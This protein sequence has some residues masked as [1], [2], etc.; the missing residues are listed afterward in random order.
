MFRAGCQSRKALTKNGSSGQLYNRF[1]NGCC[2]PDH[3]REGLIY[4]MKRSFIIIPVLLAVFVLFSAVFSQ[5]EPLADGE[6]TADFKTDSSMFKVCEANDGKGILTV[7]DGEMNIHVSLSSKNILNLFPGLAEDAKKDGAELLEPTTDEVTYSD[8][9]Q[10]TVYGFDIPVPYLDEEFDLALIGK[11]GKWYDHKVSVSS[12]EPIESA[13]GSGIPDG[14]Y[15]CEVTLEGGSGKASVS[16]PA[17]VEITDGAP[18][19]SVIWSSP[20]Y[21]YMIVGETRYE[22]VRTEG[23]SAFEIPVVLDSDMEVSACTLAM[24]QPHLIDYTL[25]FDSSTLK[26]FAEQ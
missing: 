1:F 24:S 22:P 8:G 9:F 25:H 12:P 20:Y 3:Y 10:D 13:A 26:E 15:L 7:R 23:N 6:Y 16:S 2:L 19:A 11:K 4:S 18:T 14:S 17:V 21:E 5:A